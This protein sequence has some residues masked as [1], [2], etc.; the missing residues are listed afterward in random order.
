MTTLEESQ[1]AY[2]RERRPG[3]SGKIRILDGRK[4]L[5]VEE[6]S[7]MW[8]RLTRVVGQEKKLL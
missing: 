8:R 7:K 5:G 3:D 2:V 1:K 4:I 6:T